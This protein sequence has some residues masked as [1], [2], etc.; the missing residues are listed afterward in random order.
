LKVANPFTAVEVQLRGSLETYSN[1]GRIA[2]VPVVAYLTGVFKKFPLGGFKQHDNVEAETTMSVTYCKLE[3]DG[4][5]ILEVDALAN[6][7]KAGGVDLLE[8]YK[9]NIGG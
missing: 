2:Q 7:Y 3:I 8:T 6:I 1:S 4:Q 9:T 5:A